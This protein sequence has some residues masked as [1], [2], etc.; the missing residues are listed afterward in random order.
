GII[1]AQ[2]PAIAAAGLYDLTAHIEFNGVREAATLYGALQIDAP[3][4]FTSLEPQWGPMAGGT[5]VTIYGEGFEPGNTV[6]NGPTI[7]VG[8]S[9]AYEVNVLS[10]NKM[11]IVTPRGTPGQKTVYGK[12]R[13]G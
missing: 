2:V 10:S 8:S 11:T 4:R 6:I 3:I 9:P 5:T 12:D 13:Y 7:G 1:K